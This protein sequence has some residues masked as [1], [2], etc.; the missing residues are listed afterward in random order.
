MFYILIGMMVTWAYPFVKTVQLRHAHFNV[1]TL[2]LKEIKEACIVEMG[3]GVDET[4]TA[5]FD[6]C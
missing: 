1:R 6:H 4:I 3:R 5:E 2:Y